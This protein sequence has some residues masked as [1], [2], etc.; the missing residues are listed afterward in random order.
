MLLTLGI[1]FFLLFGIL[2]PVHGNNLDSFLGFFL[3]SFCAYIVLGQNRRNWLAATLVFSWFI[4]YQFKEFS[5]APIWG[6]VSG[7]ALT[8]LLDKF[9]LVAKLAIWVLIFLFLSTAAVSGQD[10]RNFLANDLAIGTY[11]NDPG[12]LFKTY[13]LM[14]AG[15]D[16][17]DAFAT[18]QLGRFSQQIVSHDVWGWRLPTIFYIWKLVPGSGGLSIYFLYLV[19]AS[20]LLFAA[21]KI[22]QRYLDFPISILPSYLIFPYLHFGAR[23]QMFLE[24]EWWSIF[25]FIAGLY[26]LILRKLF[27]ATVILALTVLVREVYILPIGLLFIF[28]IVKNKRLAPVF[29]IALGAFLIFFLYHVYRVNFYIDAWGTLFSPR[30]IENGLFFVQQTLAFASWEYFFFWL[31]PLTIFLAASIVGCWFLIK[32]GRK[33]EGIIWLL[34]FL[35]FPIS[36]LR[37][38]SVPYNDYWGLIYVP[39]A[40]ILAPTVLGFFKNINYTRP[41]GRGIFFRSEID[42]TLHPRPKSRGF[43]FL[44]IKYGHVKD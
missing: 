28:A 27:W 38:G 18:A 5:L 32:Q 44:V 13:L 24:T 12:I 2:N 3:F 17:Y 40:I 10:L 16:Y 34:A 33:E 37:F 26:F 4:F 31:R 15:T 23:D 14:E 20:I 39:L 30:T 22:G 25:L 1:I 11:N 21:F 41:K 8:L 7:L 43:R 35:P 29:L 42:S 36:F 19:L 9:K 6:S